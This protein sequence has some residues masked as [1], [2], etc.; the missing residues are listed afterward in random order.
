MTAFVVRLIRGSLQ[1]GKNFLLLQILSVLPFLKI[2]FFS[3]IVQ[4]A[5]DWCVE[6]LDGFITPSVTIELDQYQA[7]AQAKAVNEAREEFKKLLE[8]KDRDNEKLKSERDEY[9]RRLV[10]LGD[11]RPDP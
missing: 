10:A 7:E 4:K 3:Y 8:Q 5:I 1:L 6:K 11:M 2:P 9:K